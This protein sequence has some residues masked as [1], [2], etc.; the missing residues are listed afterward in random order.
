M[1]LAIRIYNAGAPEVMQLEALDLPSPGPGE[2][3]LEQTAIGVNPLDVSQRKGLVPI[4]LPSGLGLEGAG[5]VAAVGAG[6]SALKVGDRVGYATGPLGAYAS[7]RLFPADR[8]IRLPDALGD[9]AAASVLFKGITAQY[10]LKTTGQVRQGSRVLIYGAA[11]ALGQLMCTWAKHLG[12]QVLGVVSKPASVERA[13]AAGCDQV[14]VFEAQSLPS[15]V[16][17]ATQ[18]HMADVV[19]DP[20]GKDTFSASLDCLRPRGLMVSFGATS[21]LP[22]A[23]EPGVLNAKG[24]LFLTRPSLA[25]HTATIEEYQSRAQD[26][27]DA[28]AAG[29]LRPQVWKSY[30]LKD[31]AA[32]HA[33]LEQGRSQGSIILTP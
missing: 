12:A 33:D 13:K 22:P 3:L 15:Q 25:A 2:V 32:A 1:A 8:L 21:G 5:V 24:S 26:V 4:A 30:A 14:F 23:V 31:A 9:D 18:G 11:G 17:Q 6:V 27:L 20:I 7:A 10:L 29:I 16:M 19:Y 28:I